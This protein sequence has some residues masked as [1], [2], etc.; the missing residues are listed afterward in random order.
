MSAL[1]R[2]GAEVKGLKPVAVYWL[3]RTALA[4][5][6]LALVL[7]ASLSEAQ[8]RRSGARPD[9]ARDGEGVIVVTFVVAAKAVITDVSA[10]ETDRIRSLLA[11]L[12]RMPLRS[13]RIG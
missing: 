13:P 3:Q 1:R 4:L 5:M 9:R 2:A 10:L 7:T 11:E 8:R 6:V 12:I